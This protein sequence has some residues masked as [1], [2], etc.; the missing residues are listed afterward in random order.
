[1]RSTRIRT[2]PNRQPPSFRREGTVRQEV[3]NYLGKYSDGNSRHSAR[4]VAEDLGENIRTVSSALSEFFVESENGALL[5]TDEGLLGKI[6]RRKGSRAYFYWFEG[7]SPLSQGD[8]DKLHLSY[9]NT[10]DA[11]CGIKSHVPRPAWEYKTCTA[12][13]VGREGASFRHSYWNYISEEDLNEW[14]AEGW[15][16]VSACFDEDATSLGILSVILRREKT[17]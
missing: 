8:L 15:E 4:Q 17:P 13:S 12:E 11:S 3:L 16:V 14:G 9:A 6:R 2:G 7:G 10:E 5:P 1:M